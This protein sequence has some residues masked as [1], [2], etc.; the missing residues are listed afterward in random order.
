[1]RGSP[2][3]GLPAFDSKVERAALFLSF[4][5][6]LSLFGLTTLEALPVSSQTTLSNQSTIAFAYWISFWLLSIHI[7]FVVPTLVGA[8][9][10]NSFGHYFCCRPSRNSDNSKYSIFGTRNLPWCIRIPIKLSLGSIV[11]VFNVLYKGYYWFFSRR[12]RKNASDVL[13]L[14]EESIAR[15]L[16]D[17]I[18]DDSLH[19]SK[20][21][22]GADSSS[23]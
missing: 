18:R 2:L 3:K 21:R 20:C 1:M 14:R 9:V 4:G 23:A 7:L 15:S 17:E 11:L 13:P 16:S 5:L 10:A 8:S 19:K 22:S 12:R 6:S